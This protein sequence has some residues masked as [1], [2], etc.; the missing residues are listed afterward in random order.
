MKKVVSLVCALAFTGMVSVNAAQ[1]PTQQVVVMQQ[2]KVEIK[3]DELPQAVKDVLAGEDYTGWTVAKAYK[4][5]E[6][7]KPTL[8][9]VNLTKTDVEPMTLTFD[10]EGKKPGQ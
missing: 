3:V 2:E 6:E 10:E 1:V 5:T 4:I 7:G 9:E 8:F